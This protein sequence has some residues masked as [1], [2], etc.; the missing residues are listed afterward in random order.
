MA[1]RLQVL[2]LESFWQL[3][4]VVGGGTFLF[5]AVWR[6]RPT[7]GRFRLMAAWFAVGAL[8]LVGQFLIQTH[9]EKISA[10]I[11]GM[12]TAV[13]DGDVDALGDHISESLS[14]EMSK[15]EFLRR[16]TRWLERS[17][18]DY[19]TVDSM[20]VMV[21][22]GAATA[23]FRARCRVQSPNYVSPLSISKW[24]L[25]FRLEADGQWRVI[26]IRLTHIGNRGVDSLRFWLD[27]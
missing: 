2:F 22:G 3:A 5:F 11:R 17:S 27:A 19:A 1:D 23:V 6:Q 20:D 24:E 18:V 8:C 16:A 14:G 26:H 4:T 7:P 25:G 13:D 12:A 15:E 10:V 21:D 9:P